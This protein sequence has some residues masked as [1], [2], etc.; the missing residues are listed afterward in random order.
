MKLPHEAKMS[1]SL[2]PDATPPALPVSNANREIK[3]ISH[4]ALFYWWPV[5]VAGFFMAAW[6]A[7]EDNRLAAVPPDAT[8]STGPV[9][10]TDIRTYSLKTKAAAL[11]APSDKAV[12]HTDAKNPG[13]AFPTHVSQH[14]W[15]G[16]IFVTILLLVVIITNVPLRGLWSFLVIIMILVLAL[17]VHVFHAWDSLFERVANLR[18]YINLAGYLTIAVA[19]LV[20][21]GLAVFIFDRRTY[22]IFT[23]GQIK[24]CEHIGA[25]VR[26]FDTVGVTFEKQRD[27]LFRHY[28]LGFGS[29]D[30]ILRTAGAER[31]E[32]KMP[33][34]LGIGWQLQAVE[35]MLRERAMAS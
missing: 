2:P 34:V 7:I 4:S 25:S 15:L 13:D 22:I 8:L 17:L 23:P 12:R 5:W 9:E 26:T 6:T 18:I 14:A 24:L 33:N 3:I 30:L 32:I 35:N 1:Q 27:D 10:G 20:V 11:P 16:S 28:I 21:W 31:H 29:G 19:T